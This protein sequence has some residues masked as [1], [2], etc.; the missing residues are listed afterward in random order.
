MT[1]RSRSE[2]AKL[3]YTLK[4]PQRKEFFRVWD[5]RPQGQS[6]REFCA[7]YKEEQWCPSHSHGYRWLK[8]REKIIREGLGSPT[9]RLPPQ[10]PQGRP[11]KDTSQTLEA[12]IE[13]P[14]SQTVK[15]HV[16][17]SGVS[18]ATLYRHLKAQR[19]N[20]GGQTAPVLPSHTV[21]STGDV[22]AGR[23]DRSS[24]P[25]ARLTTTQ[26]VTDH[27][28]SIA[29]RNMFCV[30]SNQDTSE[31]A[32]GPTP[33]SHRGQAAKRRENT[34][35]ACSACR[36]RKTKVGAY[37]TAQTGVVQHTHT[38]DY[39]KVRWRTSRV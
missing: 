6:M 28:S 20:Q 34:S 16:A 12:M 30:P 24:G 14:R 17:Q 9:R 33:G 36:H 23:Q 18:A 35:V 7:I 37:R 38:T 21:Q 4:S 19:Q 10:M 25:S 31:A 2:R 5:A 27:A 39:F 1:T 26:A 3:A 8:E 15:Q 32:S 11:K 29:D 13:R 22:S